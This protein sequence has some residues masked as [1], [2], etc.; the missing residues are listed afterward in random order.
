MLAKIPLEFIAGSSR[1]CKKVGFAMDFGFKIRFFSLASFGALLTMAISWSTAASAKV[2]ITGNERGD[3]DI[4]DQISYLAGQEYLLDALR[5][6]EA[7]TVL[8]YLD[9]FRKVPTDLNIGM[10]DTPIWFSYEIENRTNYDLNVYLEMPR[11]YFWIARMF[12]ISGAIVTEDAIAGI[13]VRSRDLTFYS[14]NSAF[15]TRIVKGESVRLMFYS[16]TDGPLDLRTYLSTSRDFISRS[17]RSNNVNGIFFGLI[18]GLII[19]CA[20]R[21]MTS[22]DNVYIYFLISVVVTSFLF[23]TIDGFGISFLWP[24]V[25]HWSRDL[26]MIFSSLFMFFCVKTTESGVSQNE[27]SSQEFIYSLAKYISFLFFVVPFSLPYLISG[28]KGIA[29]NLTIV[30][31]IAVMTLM[32]WASYR[33][34]QGGFRPALFMAVAFVPYI[35]GTIMRALALFGVAHGIFL[36]NVVHQYTAVVAM[37]LMAISLEDRLTYLRDQQFTENETV[38]QKNQQLIESEKLLARDQA[39]ASR[40]VQMLAHDIR[41]PFSILRIGINLISRARDYAEVQESLARLIPEIDAASGNADALMLDI[42]EMGSADLD[43]IKQKVCPEALIADTLGALETELVEQ[44]Q[45]AGR[46]LGVLLIDDDRVY[47]DRLV[48]LGKN[49]AAFAKSV[50]ITLV[51]NANDALAAVARQNCDLIITDVDLGVFSVSGFDLVKQMRELQIEALICVHSNRIAAMDHNMAAKVGADLYLPKPM[52]TA[53]LF[54]LILQACAKPRPSSTASLA[55]FGELGASH[56]SPCDLEEVI[57]V[58]DSP[59]VLESWLATLKGQAKV[60]LFSSSQELALRI[61]SQ[62]DFLND[63]CC[64]VTDLYLVGSSLD[65][66]EIARMIKTYRPDL[67]VLLSSDA[68]LTESE[69]RGSVDRVIGK[70]P[71]PL[72]KLRG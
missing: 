30:G 57:I 61:D 60:H 68:F 1:R 38:R 72:H 42:M 21:S 35:L 64:I 55:S 27:G 14:T 69:W 67:P 8:K 44:S 28:T 13:E 53:Q 34:Y 51:H 2:V 36:E 3:L 62:P 65:G 7:K 15:N 11:Q 31:M 26:M 29:I 20:Y 37:I 24:S 56:A 46:A 54:R 47:A 43:P 32:A 16:V 63:I 48:G 70:D 18:F 45:V 39:A 10:M 66:L 5:P 40:V 4:S 71:L 25:G 50:S 17:Y 19:Y 58:D 6:P 12:K 22:S 49:S 52:G 33:S 41:K 59:F 23:A 9:K